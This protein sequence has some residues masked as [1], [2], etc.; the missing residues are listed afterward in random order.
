MTRQEIVASAIANAR[1]GRRGAPPVT[2]VLELLRSISD[3]RLYHEVMDDARAVL[4]ALA[5]DGIEILEI[6]GRKNV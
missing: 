3:G 5:E 4:V 1:A 2:N 6:I